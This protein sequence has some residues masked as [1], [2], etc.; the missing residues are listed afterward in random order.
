ML[1]MLQTSVAKGK[2]GQQTIKSA[3]KE[4]SVSDESLKSPAPLS[5]AE[6][7][8]YQL[9]I[10]KARR[11]VSHYGPQLDDYIVELR[12]AVRYYDDLMKSKR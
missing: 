11:V 2:I 1:E 3:S 12:D 8:A 6:V 4:N 10:E 9:I 7:L 5:A